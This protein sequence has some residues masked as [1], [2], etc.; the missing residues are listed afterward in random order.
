MIETFKLVTGIYDTVVSPTM[1]ER[2]HHMQ[3]QVTISDYRKLGQDII[4]VNTISL[5]EL[6]IG[7]VEISV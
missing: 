2:V 4:Y 7:Y 3:Q 6:L 1:L 5:T